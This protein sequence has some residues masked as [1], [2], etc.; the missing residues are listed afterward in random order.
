MVSTTMALCAAL[1]CTP[2]EGDCSSDFTSDG[3]VNIVDLLY[4]I[5]HWNPCG[6][7]ELLGVVQEW[8]C[9]TVLNPTITA[10]GPPATIVPDQSSPIPVLSQTMTVS[11]NRILLAAVRTLREMSA[12]TTIESVTWTA[13]GGDG[14]ALSLEAD[15]AA[16]GNN[17]RL[18][19]LRTPVG[20]EGVLTVNMPPDEN[21]QYASVVSFEIA[22]ASAWMTIDAGTGSFQL[23]PDDNAGRLTIHPEVSRGLVVHFCGDNHGNPGFATQEGW[24]QIANYQIAPPLWANAVFGQCRGFIEGATIE[25]IAQSVS[26]TAS[27]WNAGL[28]FVGAGVYTPAD[29]APRIYSPDLDAW[30]ELLGTQPYEAGGMVRLAVVGDS[31]S[32]SAHTGA[33]LSHDLARG[34]IFFNRFGGSWGTRV[35]F[36]ILWNNGDPAYGSPQTEQAVWAFPPANGGTNWLSAWREGQNVVWDLGG[37]SVPGQGTDALLKDDSDESIVI[38]NHNCSYPRS[39]HWVYQLGNGPGPQIAVGDPDLSYFPIWND[40]MVRIVA[41]TKPGSGQI[42]VKVESCADFFTNSPANTSLNGTDGQNTSMALDSEKPAILTEEFGPFSWRDNANDKY[43][44]VRLKGTNAIGARLLAVEIYSEQPRGIAATVCGAVGTYPSNTVALYTST[45]AEA[46]KLWPVVF[47]ATLTFQ[48]THDV[49][50]GLTP[51]EYKADMQAQ[52][53]AIRAHAP[54]HPFIL[55][56]D[57]IAT[58]VTDPDR[59]ERHECYAGVLKDLCDENA[60]NGPMLF[61]NVLRIIREDL[62]WPIG[63]EHMASWTDHIHLG[64][65]GGDL[66][67]GAVWS[68]IFSTLDNVK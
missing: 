49:A 5:G 66:V 63:Q 64:Q 56:T 53:D 41:A 11:E 62:D 67:E 1:A 4:V 7:E 38:L 48:G 20:G 44:R 26:P 36:P 65:T 12:P 32:T 17:L 9:V 22:G 60:A 18:Y 68:E 33:G 16:W 50:V 27:F 57:W 39:S 45:F 31:R 8:G 51:L 58:D 42:N 29:Q 2:S 52:I 46:F 43:F 37:G 10:L 6:I 40:V 59:I 14:Q 13:S 15:G 54:G 47:D 30:S 24:T 28:V 34:Q 55:C 35:V 61:V 23:D 19:I 3:I 21:Q 25:A